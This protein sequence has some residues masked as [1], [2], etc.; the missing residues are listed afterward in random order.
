[1]QRKKRIGIIVLVFFLLIVIELPVLAVETQNGVELTEKTIQKLFAG[2]T[3]GTCGDNLTWNLDEKTAI[4]TINGIGN[5][6]DFRSEHIIPWPEWIKTIVIENG[7][8]NIGDGAFSETNITAI[9]LAGS[10]KKIGDYAFSTTTLPQI[11]LSE[12]VSY[13][14]KRAFEDCRYLSFI[15]IPDSVTY[16]AEDAFNKCDSIK[17]YGYADSYAEHYAKEKGI[18]FVILARFYDSQHI[19]LQIDNYDVYVGNT[20]I[21][22]DVVPK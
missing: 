15:Q 5:M 10:V 8:E 6:W 1:M 13:I 16:I 21:R 22:N 2:T 9:K 20:V 14:G 4:L 3:S 19:V 18:P 7:V 12:G 17:I 11:I